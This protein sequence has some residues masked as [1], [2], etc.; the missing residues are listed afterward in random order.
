MQPV[1]EQQGCMKFLPGSHR[2]EIVPHRSPG[3]DNRINGLEAM[4]IDLTSAVACPLPLGGATVH[5]FRTLHGTGGNSTAIPRRVLT[6]GFGIRRA[7]PT[8][9][10]NFPWLAAKDN[11]RLRRWRHTDPIDRVK[12]FAK[13]YI[14]LVMVGLRLG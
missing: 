14:N 11:T 13:P 9:E 4:G 5:H 12:A 10:G 8:V 3:G 2:S 6:V 1:D 7:R